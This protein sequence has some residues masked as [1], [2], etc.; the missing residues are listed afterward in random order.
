MTSYI[1]IQKPRRAAWACNC[2]ETVGHWCPTKSDQKGK[3]ERT[4][5]QNTPQPWEKDSR[6]LV[7]HTAPLLAW[8]SKTICRNPLSKQPLSFSRVGSDPA[9]GL[10]PRCQASGR[11]QG[12]KRCRG[13]RLHRHSR[14]FAV[15]W[16]RHCAAQD[17]QQGCS[18][19]SASGTTP[20]SCLYTPCGAEHQTWTP[21]SHQ[22]SFSP[23]VR[24]RSLLGLTCCP[25]HM[26]SETLVHLVGI[27]KSLLS[28]KS[29]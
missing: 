28:V 11:L 7:S 15:I 19:E 23:H 8:G 18:P 17:T 13:S 20:H 29:E 26:L 9:E 5:T 3:G 25:Q 4:G 16:F 10:W 1:K 24:S 22:G 21:V 27:P 6:A 2:C 14:K 12:E